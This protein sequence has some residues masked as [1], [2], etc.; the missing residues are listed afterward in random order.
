MYEK[1]TANE[2]VVQGTQGLEVLGD[3]A[4]LQSRIEKYEAARE[5]I[6]DYIDRNFHM[7]VDYGAADPRNP[8]PTLLKPG[9]EKVCRLFNTSPVWTMDRDT[10][11][12]LGSPKDLVCYKCQIKDNTT[13][14]IVGEGR[15]AEKVGN[16]GR[17]ANKAIKIAEKCALV[18]ACLYT[19]MLSEKFTQDDGGRV[20]LAELKTVLMGDITE[21]RHGQRTRSHSKGHLRR[22]G[23]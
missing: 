3:K 15:G 17:D 5:V 19:F 9:A 8:K 12:M 1:N 18:D 11:E 2:L 10:W 22:S 7:G 14:R 20:A 21:I 16:K 13:G 4:N 23:L 6:V